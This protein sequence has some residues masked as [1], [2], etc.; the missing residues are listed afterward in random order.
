[1]APMDVLTHPLLELSGVRAAYGDIEIL[2]GV[3][4]VVP[5][6]GVVALLGPN[7]AGKSSTVK[8]CAGLLKPTAGEVKIAGADVTGA[9]SD[10]LARLG[11]CTIPEGR[12]VF[13]NLTVRE[14]LW[15]ATQAG[16]SRDEVE[17]RAFARFPR[18]AERRNQLA[19]TM[20]GGEQ[21]MLAMSRALVTDPAVL[22]LDELSMGLAPLIVGQLYEI[23]KHVA[24]E[25]VSILVVEQFATAVLGIAD[26][27]AIMLHGEITSI[28]SPTDIEAEL[29]SA[30]L[31]G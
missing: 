4:L 28:G 1:M 24:D 5:Q 17:E 19:G 27:A 31:G 12:G 10:Q 30:Y 6:G 29:S 21:Q 23:V 9:T 22:L 13:P 25:G 7:G 16:P 18:L 3:D 15:M 2:H 8:V 14:N 20:S 11:V 26:I